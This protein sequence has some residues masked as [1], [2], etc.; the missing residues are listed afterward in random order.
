MELP[1]TMKA[2]DNEETEG[3]GR[4][5]ED[6]QPRIL[7]PMKVTFK[8]E[9]E[10]KIVSEQGNVKGLITNRSSLKERIKEVLL[11]EGKLHQTVANLVL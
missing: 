1:A 5:G 8:N 2:E 11:K 4:T 9:T 10:I 6:C 3:T 7:Q